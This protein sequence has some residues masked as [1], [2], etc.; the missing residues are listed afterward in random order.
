MTMKKEN[1]KLPPSVDKF[2]LKKR[3]NTT[4]P[5]GEHCPYQ[6]IQYRAR[7]RKGGQ[8][9]YINFDLAQELEI[10]PQ[11]YTPKMASS[12]EKQILDLF[13]YQIINE[14]DVINKIQFQKE[15]IYPNKVLATRYL[16]LQHLDNQG[17]NSGDGRGSWVGT[18]SAKGKTFDIS[19]TGSGGTRLSPATHKHERYFQSG[20]PSI[21]YG[22]GHAELSETI[23]AALMS[24]YFYR[25]DIPTER[26]L[27]VIKFPNQTAI[28]IRVGENLLRP[29][30]FFLHVK[31]NNLK[32]LRDIFNVY[33]QREISNKK[34]SSSNTYELYQE[35][36]TNITTSF[37][38][39]SATFEM[40]HI[41]VWMDWDGDNILCDGGIIDYGSIR[42][43][44][45]CYKNYR[46]DDDGRWSTS[47]LQQKSMAKKTV[48]YFMQAVDYLQTGDKKNIDEYSDHPIGNV[49]EEIFEKERLNLLLKKFG[50]DSSFIEFA[51]AQ[52]RK[53]S[54]RLLTS[55]Q[56]LERIC[57]GSTLQKT[58][59]GVFRPCLFNTRVILKNIPSLLKSESKVT[60]E[61]LR[62]VLKH[63][64]L[65]EATQ[66]G[67]RIS[68]EHVK[69]LK[70][71]LKNFKNLFEVY[72]N[73]NSGNFQKTKFK[74]SSRMIKINSETPLTGDGVISVTNKIIS[75]RNLEINDRFKII[76]Q[77]L[78]SLLSKNHIPCDFER[79]ILDLLKI[80]ED[81]EEGI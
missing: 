28:Y 45:A 27:A 75:M 48:T 41:F 60:Q 3:L 70:G 22:C 74:L 55:F 33:V 8:V 50:F 40:D 80:V 4:H 73:K 10:I 26:C 21:S 71:L 77:L 47:L 12:L 30:H 1:L 51:I 66:H 34:M 44:G 14:Y 65:N 35:F 42:K 67:A 76:D 38:K 16:Q 52:H 25:Q 6:A 64:I 54:E 18:I 49:F 62:K 43:F 11:N 17:K 31:Q 81:N 20:D 58:S 57:L 23:N 78:K 68:N 7:K 59:D 13:S 19:C 32:G 79:R 36:I 29:S 24:E 61:E 5:I 15:D 53:T 63:A 69:A 46:F 37:A 2:D 9:Y 39:A 72:N 56:S